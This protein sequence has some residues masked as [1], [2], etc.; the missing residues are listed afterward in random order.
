MRGPSLLSVL[1]AQLVVAAAAI[2]VP[3]PAGAQP[4]TCPAPGEDVVNVVV[5]TPEPGATVTG[6]IEV[7]GR[8]EAPTLLFQIELFV[9]DSRKDF[10]LLDPPVEAA[11]FTMAW[12]ASAAKAGPAPLHVVACG[13][14]TEFGRLIRG[15]ADFEVQVDAAP[16]PTPTGPKLVDAEGEKGQRP[17]LVAGAVIAVPAVACL[18][19]AIGRRRSSPARATTPASEANE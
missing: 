13:G 5:S 9:G 14:T 4:A 3:G 10:V 6:R 17:S 11:D 16:S 18:V 19:Y 8:V 1:V 12:D 7:T 2:L 15:A